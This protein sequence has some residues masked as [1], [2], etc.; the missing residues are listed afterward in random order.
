MSMRYAKV[1]IDIVVLLFRYVEQNHRKA[2]ISW[3][4][5]SSQY[6]ITGLQEVRNIINWNELLF[7]VVYDKS[8]NLQNP[9]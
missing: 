2:Y 6:V 1:Y 5:T 9:Y 8:H 7:T 4:F 3:H